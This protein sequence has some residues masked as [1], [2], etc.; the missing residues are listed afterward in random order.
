MKTVCHISSLP[1]K[2]MHYIFLL[3]SW[4][5]SK[6]R[7]QLPLPIQKPLFLAQKHKVKIIS[8]KLT[9]AKLVF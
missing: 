7:V 6:L 5:N 8:L 2:Q 3:Y 4:I 1:N 9:Y